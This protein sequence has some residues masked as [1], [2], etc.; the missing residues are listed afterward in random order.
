MK[1]YYLM[2]IKYKNDKAMYELADYYRTVEKNYKKMKKYYFMGIEN[3]NVKSMFSLGYY[4]DIYEKDYENMKKY[5][6]MGIKNNKNEICVDEINKCI[7]YLEEYDE[8][9][10]YM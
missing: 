5:Y 1:K 3:N 10:I 8:Y 7:E 2:A 6:L 9:S 4:Y